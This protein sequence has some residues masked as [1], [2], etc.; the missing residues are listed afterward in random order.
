MP[1][2]ITVIGRCTI[3]FDH[4]CETLC[5]ADIQWFLGNHR[6]ETVKQTR[7]KE[8]RVSN[9]KWWHQMS[10]ETYSS[11]SFETKSVSPPPQKYQRE[12]KNPRKVKSSPSLHFPAVSGRERGM[13]KINS[14]S[15]NQWIHSRKQIFRKK[16]QTTKIVLHSQVNTDNNTAIWT[17]QL[18]LPATWCKNSGSW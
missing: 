14:E 15:I 4:H 5:S 10:F 2:H 11:S 17:K 1:A 16:I 13:A 12:K 18:I 9:K 6:L 8:F 3:R 7:K